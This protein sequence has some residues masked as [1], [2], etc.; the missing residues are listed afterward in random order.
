MPQFL[1]INSDGLFIEDGQLITETEYGH[2]LL[3]NLRIHQGQIT[4]YLD[5][6]QWIVEA[7]DSPFVALSLE[8]SPTK[9]WVI[10]CNYNFKASF[11]PKTL[12]LDPWD[13]FLGTTEHNIPFV[14]SPTAQNTLFDLVDSFDDD[15]ITIEGQRIPTPSWRISQP[16]IS[17]PQY[18]DD[19]YERDSTPWDLGSP[20]PALREYFPKLKLPRS[21]ILVLGAGRGQDAALMAQMGNIVTAVDFSKQALQKARASFS[22]LTQIEWVE[23]NIFSLPTE[24]HQN[25]D[26]VLEHT[27][28]SAIDP[29]ERED[30]V[31][32]W[33][34]CLAPG[35]R[36]LGIFYI[37]PQRNGPP[38]GASEWEIQKRLQSHFRI[39]T[40]SRFRQSVPDRLGCE[41]WVQAQLI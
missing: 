28:F 17:L 20:A 33:R 27:C 8:R 24:F 38:F 25:F 11:D 2:Q 21:R 18:W 41:L 31:K 39:L 23:H 30:L 9:T 10:Q 22:G 40:W 3:E 13:R 12:A 6:K 19:R 4:T 7:Y 29:E 32:M 37:H 5:E 14:L 16:E 35:G 26:I 15:S 34:K 36:L 1:Q